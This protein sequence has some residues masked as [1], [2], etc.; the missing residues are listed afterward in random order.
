MKRDLVKQ[1]VTVIDRLE[2]GLYCP[3]DASWC[4]DRVVWL[5]KFGHISHQTMSE[6]CTRITNLFEQERTC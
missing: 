4:A 1:V 2:K 5:Y 6:L 3:L